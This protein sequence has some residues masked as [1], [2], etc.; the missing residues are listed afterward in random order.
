MKL[1]AVVLAHLPGLL[2]RCLPSLRGLDEVIVAAT[3]A[4]RRIHERARYYGATPVSIDW[5]QDFAR[6]RN[7]AQAFVRNEWVLHVDSDEVLSELGE[8]QTYDTPEALA[9]RVIHENDLG[10][11]NLA[12][13]SAC[14][15]VR[16][17]VRWV[18]AVHEYV[19]GVDHA[20]HCPVIR[21]WH[22]GYRPEHIMG[23]T[24]RNLAIAKRMAAENP[25]DPRAKALIRREMAWM[26]A[27]TKRPP[28]P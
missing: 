27:L 13:S 2:D 6:A 28:E 25:S 1:S 26:A 18:S 8:L 4:D 11:G 21:L 22:D 10:D 17:S 9:Y 16:R 19:E 23:K 24:R 12:Q 14:R 3:V 7:A 5:H 15:L 20:P